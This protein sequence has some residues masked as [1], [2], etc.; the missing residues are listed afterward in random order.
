MCLDYGERLPVHLS[1][2][3]CGRSSASFFWGGFIFTSDWLQTWHWSEQGVDLY[4]N[5]LMFCSVPESIKNICCCEEAFKKQQN[6]PRLIKCLCFMFKA[7]QSL[8]KYISLAAF[9]D[10]HHMVSVKNDSQLLPTPKISSIFVNIDHYSHFNVQSGCC[11]PFE[12]NWSVVDAHP[13][14]PFWKCL[15]KSVQWFFRYFANRHNW[16]Q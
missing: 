14:I 1:P 2:S 12:I 4:R 5:N 6:V 15:L 13:T 10:Q 7:Q 16:P 3:S 11:N 9:H 8:K